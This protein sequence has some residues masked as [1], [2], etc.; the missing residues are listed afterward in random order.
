MTINK[1]FDLFLSTV[2]CFLLTP[3]FLIVGILIKLDSKGPVFFRQARLGLNGKLFHIY[4]FRTM[5]EGAETVGS[6]IT[7]INDPR[8]TKIGKY[9]RK[10]KLDE[11]PQLINV[12]KGEMSL[13]GPR[14]EVPKYLP[15][16]ED[17]APWVL[18]VKP[19]ITD[20]ASLGFRN[21]SE[22]LC[23]EAE[24][25]ENIYIGQVLPKKL[26]LNRIWVDSP[27][28]KMYFNILIKT[29]SAIIMR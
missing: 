10:Y 8:V 6:K 12:V 2:S 11:L 1:I 21:E 19:G 16:F 15:Y 29:M 17:N 5:D 28:L 18:S 13:V 3:L 9:L 14:P 24:E 22:I 27:S 23:G 20:Y 7:G 25:I 4:K 26:V